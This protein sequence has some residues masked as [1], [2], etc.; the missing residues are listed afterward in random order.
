MTYLNLPGEQVPAIV[1]K[2]PGLMKLKAYIVA[3]KEFRQALLILSVLL[4]VAGYGFFVWFGRK[5]S[6]DPSTVLRRKV[7]ARLLGYGSILLALLIGFFA[8]FLGGQLGDVRLGP[9]PKG[10]PVSLLS[11]INPDADPVQLKKTIK[12]VLGALAEIDSKHL[13]EADA[14]KVMREKIA[15]ELM[16]VSRCPD[17]VMDEG[18]YFE[19]FKSMSDR[20]KEA[21][22]ELL[23]TF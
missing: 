4:L 17:F 12:L 9:I 10:T 11:N 15:P 8:Y 5:A 1:A 23:K 7:W 2:L 20:D 21:V 16:K 18:H 3:A 14:Q 13:T 22:I 19:W 6:P